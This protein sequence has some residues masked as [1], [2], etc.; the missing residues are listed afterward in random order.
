V[1]FSSLLKASWLCSNN[2][3][4]FHLLN[5]SNSISSE[6]CIC[7]QIFQRYRTTRQGCRN[8]LVKMWWLELSFITEWRP[9][10]HQP[11]TQ[12]ST[13]RHAHLAFK[14]I[15]QCLS[16]W[17]IHSRLWSLS[18]ISSTSGILASTPPRLLLSVEHVSVE[19]F[20]SAWQH[21]GFSLVFEV[22]ALSLWLLSLLVGSSSFVSPVIYPYII[23]VKPSGLVSKRERE[24][25]FRTIGRR[26]ESQDIHIKVNYLTRHN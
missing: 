5:S 6:R 7:L 10:Q 22:L 12:N 11:C 21:L 8:L 1:H 19:L 9:L 3:M 15:P 18:S 25:K 20:S 13:A 23:Q 4:E 16:T 2:Q 24:S 14:V 17:H 26:Y